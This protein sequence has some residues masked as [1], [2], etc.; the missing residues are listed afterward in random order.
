MI[1]KH[2]MENDL[3][4][5][6]LKDQFLAIMHNATSRRAA[7]DSL[8]EFKDGILKRAFRK[9]ALR[10]HPDRKGDA[11]KFRQFQEAYKRLNSVTL[12]ERPRPMVIEI[13]V[14]SG[15][16]QWPDHGGATTS[17]TSGW[18]WNMP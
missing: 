4:L 7:Q 10:H 16:V 18:G 12:K 11:T 14:N 1:T 3:D 8:K 2:T 6:G 5:F 15:S 17:S 9:A 13:C